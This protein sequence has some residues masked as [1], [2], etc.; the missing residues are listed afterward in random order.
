MISFSYMQYIYWFVEALTKTNIL[1][2]ASLNKTVFRVNVFAAY[3]A[4]SNYLV[5]FKW[6]LTKGQQNIF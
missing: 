2:I 5:R 3:F 6:F 1:K 4:Q